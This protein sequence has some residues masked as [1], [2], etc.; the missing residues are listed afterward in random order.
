VSPDDTTL[1]HCNVTEAENK[2]GTDKARN[3]QKR[4]STI[5]LG[6]L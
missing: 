4:L 2:N 3:Q 1:T 5:Y 6:H